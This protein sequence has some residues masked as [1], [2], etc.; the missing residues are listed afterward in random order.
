MGSGFSFTGHTNTCSFVD[1]RRNADRDGLAFVNPTFAATDFARIFDDF[2][3]AMAGRTGT[4]DHEKAL[5]SPNFTMSRAQVA[6]A[7]S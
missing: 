5:L 1:T 2:A 6:T 3:S 7:L 4:L